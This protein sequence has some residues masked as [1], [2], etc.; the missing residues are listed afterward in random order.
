MTEGK[1]IAII[2]ASAN[3]EKYGNKAVRAY[4][5]QG[6]R[7]YPVTPNA[8]E[9]EGIPAFKSVRDIPGEVE[10][11]SLYVPPQVGVRLLEEIAKKKVREVYVNPGAESD[12]LLERANELGLRAIVA[13]SILA[14]GMTPEEV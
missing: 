12:E 4:V 13:C 2:G 1:T 14:I 3:R 6:Y 7:V 9:V 11:A 10:I 8:P 5:K